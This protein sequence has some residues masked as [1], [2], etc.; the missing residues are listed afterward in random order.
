MYE[1][2]MKTI[3]IDLNSDKDLKAYDAVLNDPSCVVL[4]EIQEKITNKFFNDE[5]EMSGIE[6]KIVRVI[7]YQKREFMGA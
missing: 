3:R 7:T 2:V 5:G 1:A 4:R 6:E